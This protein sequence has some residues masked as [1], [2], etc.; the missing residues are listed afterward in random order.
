M[1]NAAP[2]NGLPVVTFYK[3]VPVANG[4]REDSYGVWKT[5]GKLRVT[6]DEAEHK[7]RYLI[8][9]FNAP[10]SR[11]Y[12]FKCVF[13]LTEGQI[14]EAIEYAMRPGV[15][16]RIKYFNAVTKRMLAEAGH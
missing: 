1:G 7:V 16:N 8:T 14:Q 11:R 15:K 2:T 10:Q 5:C 4:I 13:H 6:T 12:F 3:K 9:L